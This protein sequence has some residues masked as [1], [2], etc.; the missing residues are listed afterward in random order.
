MFGG[1]F[2]LDLPRRSSLISFDLLRINGNL[3]GGSG[4][5]K[6]ALLARP[7]S[8]PVATSLLQGS[9]M[10]SPFPSCSDRTSR[11]PLLLLGA[12]EG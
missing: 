6:S 12:I 4:G 1:R 5:K 7:I 10:F 2:R 3:V 8:T 11:S 9:T